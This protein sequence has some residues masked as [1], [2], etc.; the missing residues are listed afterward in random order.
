MVLSVG[1]IKR[2]TTLPTRAWVRTRLWRPRTATSLQRSDTVGLAL[3]RATKWP[4]M[5]ATTTHNGASHRKRHAANAAGMRVAVFARHTR[6]PSP[7]RAKPTCRLALRGTACRA[8]YLA[9]C[10]R[11]SHPL[12]APR[13]RQPRTGCAA[14]PGR[15]RGCTRLHAGAGLPAGPVQPTHGLGCVSGAWLSHGGKQPRFANSGSC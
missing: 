5:M 13:H 4:L 1:Y 6:D 9:L 12:P 11:P 15:L 3:N 2:V 14:Q 8:F 10:L 7:C